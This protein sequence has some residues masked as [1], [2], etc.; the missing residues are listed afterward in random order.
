MHYMYIELEGRR[1]CYTIGGGGGG[2]GGVT[3]AEIYTM[4]NMFTTL[5][6]HLSI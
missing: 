1:Y 3:S 4:E 5:Y 6:T 2:G